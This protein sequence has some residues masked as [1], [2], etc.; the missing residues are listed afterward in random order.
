[1]YYP[2]KTKWHAQACLLN[3]F[4]LLNKAALPTSTGL[5]QKYHGLITAPALSRM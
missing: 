2:Y 4:M 5:N 1:M 3:S